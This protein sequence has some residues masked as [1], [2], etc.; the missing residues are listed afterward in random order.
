[1]HGNQRRLTY[2]RH[3]VDQVLDTQRR[4]RL[5]PPRRPDRA[6]PE[7][8]PQD[9]RDVGGSQAVGRAGYGAQLPLERG[10][11][12]LVPRRPA[13]SLVFRGLPVHLH[14][15]GVV[16]GRRGVLDAGGRALLRGVTGLPQSGS[17][18]SDAPSDALP[19]EFGQPGPRGRGVRGGRGVLR[20]GIFGWTVGGGRG[21]AVGGSGGG[22]GGNRFLDGDVGH[23]F[24]KRWTV[25]K[26]NPLEN[27]YEFGE[28]SKMLSVEYIHSETSP[29]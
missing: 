3:R 11:L 22:G 6:P 25:Q 23:V 2:R 1:M 14:D 7:A 4:R 13:G 17:D 24:S 20:W 12:A 16:V 28:T 19:Q 21:G 8:V 29:R 15:D 18:S 9:A 27:I 26:L 10:H 5:G